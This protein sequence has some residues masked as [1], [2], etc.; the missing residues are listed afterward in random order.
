MSNFHTTYKVRLQKNKQ[1]LVCVFF[2]VF[3][4]AKKKRVSF[5]ACEIRYIQYFLYVL[6][7]AT[8]G[9]YCISQ[10]TP[11]CSHVYVVS[12]IDG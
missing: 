10:R 9:Y 5:L 8:N 3:S 12:G 11:R 2:L 4:C 6:Y 7:L 1:K